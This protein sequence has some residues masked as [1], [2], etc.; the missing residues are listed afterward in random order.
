MSDHDDDEFWDS[1]AHLSPHALAELARRMH[2]ARRVHNRRHASDRRGGASL[3]P[4]RAEAWAW[5]SFLAFSSALARWSTMFPLSAPPPGRGPGLAGL[6]RL[7][8]SGTSQPPGGM[9]LGP[10]AAPPPPFAPPPRRP[11]G[12]R[13]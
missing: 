5:S 2:T 8:A 6:P 1:M 10:G 7:P 13:G 4:S 9:Q 11:A 12:C 3:K